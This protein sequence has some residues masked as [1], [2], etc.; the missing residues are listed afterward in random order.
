MRTVLWGS[1]AAGGLMAFLLCMTGGAGTAQ[2]AGHWAK[3]GDMLTGRYAPAVTTL[4]DGR[5]LVAGGYSET[6]PGVGTCTTSAQLFRADPQG[7]GAWATTGAMAVAR[8]FATATLL[9]DGQVLI[10][11]GYN[12][13]VGTLDSVELYDPATGTFSQP[14]GAAMNIPRE[15]HTAIKLPA[16]AGKYAGKVLL[17]GGYCIGKG[18]QR[19]AEVYDPATHKFT[20][21][22][23]MQAAWGRFGHAA[24]LLPN[25]DVLIVGGKER[26]RKGWNALASV[27]VFHTTGPAAGTFTALGEMM[28][29]RDRP[30]VVWLPA[31]YNKALVI[32]GQGINRLTGASVD[33]LHCEWID[34]FAATPDRVFRLGPAL[35]HGRMAHSLVTLPNGDILVFGGWSVK[36][37]GTTNT[38]E[39]FVFATGRIVS[40]GTLACDATDSY[41]C[42]D[43]GAALVNGQVLVVGGK[44]ATPTMG[45]YPPAARIYMP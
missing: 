40:A 34:P 26:T 6:S 32:G 2:Q 29:A 9:D 28:F 1:R 39:R 31:P 16:S 22:A 33:V 14:Q 23:P 24:A 36:L 4:A 11:G 45:T 38:A 43:A 19:T 7:G 12:T 37:Q 42:H 8:N 18:T 20:L 30:T 13:E 10:A 17:I 44:Q 27:E 25:G 5:A 21:T 15:L 41:S 3:V 35:W